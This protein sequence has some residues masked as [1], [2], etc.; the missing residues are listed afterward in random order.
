MPTWKAEL[1]LKVLG[2]R[3]KHMN[4]PMNKDT[5]TYSKTNL[6]TNQ[7]MCTNTNTRVEHIN[8]RTQALQRNT[9]SNAHN[10]T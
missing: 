1:P 10:K 5:N 3:A 2:G 4:R 6:P 8:Q 9:E 7:P